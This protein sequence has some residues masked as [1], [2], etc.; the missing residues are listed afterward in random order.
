MEPSPFSMDDIRTPAALVGAREIV[1]AD[2]PPFLLFHH[3]M[4]SAENHDFYSYGYTAAQMHSMISGTLLELEESIEECDC[5]DCEN[6]KDGGN[7]FK[8]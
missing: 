6:Y 5:K 7:P 8:P 3:C 2:K 4:E 1:N